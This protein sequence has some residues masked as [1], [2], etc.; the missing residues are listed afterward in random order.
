MGVGTKGVEG[1]AEIE[2]SV[3]DSVAVLEFIGE[4][5]VGL[6]ELPINPS[7]VEIAAGVSVGDG[8]ESEGKPEIEGFDEE[9]VEVVE[10]EEEL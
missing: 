7:L 1:K 6:G 10:S 5:Q 4:V 3:E 9:S 8:P 2:D